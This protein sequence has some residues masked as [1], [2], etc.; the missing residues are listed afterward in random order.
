MLVRPIIR[1]VVGPVYRRVTEAGSNWSPMVLFAAGEQ[2]AWY[3]PSYLSTLYQDSAGTTPVTALGQPVGL[4]LDKSKGTRGPEIVTN[5]GFNDDITGWGDYGFWTAG[6]AE[7]VNGAI[8]VTTASYQGAV[9]VLPTTIGSRYEL[10]FTVVSADANAQAGRLYVSRSDPMNPGSSPLLNLSPRPPG[11]YVVHFV[12]TNTSHTIGLS[13]Q[14]SGGVV[15]WDNISV[16]ELHGK[17]ASQATATARPT[18]ATGYKID[19]DGVDD[20]LTTTFPDLGTNVTIARSIP[21]TGASILTGQT[22]GAGAWND[23][24]D[25]H[26]LVI[27]DRGLTA[28]E[29][30]NLTRW[31]N[32]RAGL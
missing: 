23:S 26:A 10:R 19:Y 29:T 6:A 27:I 3:D 1:P 16:R 17:H 18:L 7:W 4:M 22:I 32:R 8:S 28:A 9:H 31:L 21:G 13:S 20:K 5:G 2:G 12:A 14:N 24:T 30:T 11:N 25:S 15:V